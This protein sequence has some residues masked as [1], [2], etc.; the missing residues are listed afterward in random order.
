MTNPRRD[1]DI[2]LLTREAR[3]EIAHRGAQLPRLQREAHLATNE[4]ASLCLSGCAERA[5]TDVAGWPRY[6]SQGLHR[7]HR[8]DSGKETIPQLRVWRASPPK[9]RKHKEVDRGEY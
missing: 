3:N 5:G 7:N 9:A 4:S 6:C 1:S 2:S 8:G